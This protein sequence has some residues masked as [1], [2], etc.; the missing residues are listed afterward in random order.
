[1]SC[2]ERLDRFVA[3][4]EKS[5][6]VLGPRMVLGHA[7]NGHHV[8]PWSEAAEQTWVEYASETAIVAPPFPTLVTA[9]ILEI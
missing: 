3:W 8:V 6:P 4:F 9:L 2:L 7:L 1:M 5:V